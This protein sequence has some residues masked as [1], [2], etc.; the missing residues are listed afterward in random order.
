MHT[1]VIPL[2]PPAAFMPILVAEDA[3]FASAPITHSLENIG[4]TVSHANSGS[5]ALSEM[6]HHQFKVVFMDVQLP[7]MGGAKATMAMRIREKEEGGH[8]TIIAMSRQPGRA[9][10]QTLSG[11]RNGSLYFQAGEPG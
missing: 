1:Q 6:T 4:Y 2:S 7:E 11:L 8:V 5:E 9:R 3:L 10:P